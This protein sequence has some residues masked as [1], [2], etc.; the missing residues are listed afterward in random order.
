MERVRFNERM[1]PQCADVA[2]RKVP[3]ARKILLK[4]LYSALDP[5]YGT[6]GL[7]PLDIAT[8]ISY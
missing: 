7:M 8:V 4:G 5:F 3:L 2:M 1:L 6:L